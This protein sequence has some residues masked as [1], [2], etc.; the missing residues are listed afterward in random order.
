MSKDVIKKDDEMMKAL[1][2]LK[3]WVEENPEGY[4]EMSFRKIAEEAGVSH[5]TVSRSLP[6]IIAERDNILPSQV[7]FKRREAGFTFTEAGDMKL[8]DDLIKKIWELFNEKYDVDD[9]AY[10]LKI[11]KRTVEKYLS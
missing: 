6:E 9:I 4:L 11:D 10:I 3:K 5:P 2:K 1:D 8:S 7:R